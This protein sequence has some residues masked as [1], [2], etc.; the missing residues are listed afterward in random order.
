M[1]T[2]LRRMICSYAQTNIPVEAFNKK[3]LQWYQNKIQNLVQDLVYEGI[4]IIKNN[5]LIYQGDSLI[6]KED[7]KS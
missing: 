2:Y 7:I 3:M 6:I 5:R 1:E 4:L